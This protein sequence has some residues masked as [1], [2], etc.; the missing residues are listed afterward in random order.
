MAA[1]I[2]YEKNAMTVCLDG[3][4]DHHSAAIIRAGIDEAVLTARPETL[5][6]DFGSVTFMDSSGIGMIMGRYKLIKPM[7]GKL[8]VANVPKSLAKMMK[9]SGIEKLCEIKESEATV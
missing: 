7:G 1:K 8:T 6:L 3:E 5:I 4:I 9:M 2:F